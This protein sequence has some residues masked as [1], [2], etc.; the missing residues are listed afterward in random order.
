[1]WFVIF[2]VNWG[3]SH[4]GG[5]EHEPNV[6]PGDLAVELCVELACPGQ[7]FVFGG[8]VGIHNGGCDDF[9][10]DFGMMRFEIT[11]KLFHGA[12]VA[13][14]ASKHNNLIGALKGFGDRFVKAFGFVVALSIVGL[15]G[16]VGVK[17]TA[18]SMG[19][20]GFDL[21]G[22]SILDLGAINLRLVVVNYNEQMKRK[23]NR[24]RHGKLIS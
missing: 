21:L 4:P 24:G 13:C 23:R 16:D 9:G 6:A 3:F 5:L 2:V 8:V 17:M 14:A 15:A 12:S 7:K 11:Q 10:R 1:M 22:H 20:I 19:I 18:V